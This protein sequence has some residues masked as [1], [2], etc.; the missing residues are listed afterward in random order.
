MYFQEPFKSVRTSIK[1]EVHKWPFHSM[2]SEYLLVKLKFLEW[3]NN[4]CVNL[5]K[6]EEL[7]IF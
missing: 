4:K 6:M 2:N 5:E 3:W 7:Y 1:E